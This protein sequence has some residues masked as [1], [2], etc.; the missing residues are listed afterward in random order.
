MKVGLRRYAAEVG[1]AADTGIVA[2]VGLKQGEDLGC[3]DNLRAKL[4]RLG[5]HRRLATYFATASSFKTMMNGMRMT[6]PRD[7]HT[8]KAGF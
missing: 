4:G 6:A 1:R 3:I 7:R 8:G 5:R 2:F